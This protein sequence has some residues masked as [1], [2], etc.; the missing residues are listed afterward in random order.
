M[1]LLLDADGVVL[2]KHRYFSER[3][4]EERGVAIAEITPFFKNEFVRCQ[5]GQADLKEVLVPYLPKWKWDGTAD[6]FLDYWFTHDTE[7]DGAVLT[8]VARLRTAGTKCYLAS[9]QEKYRAAY[10]TK[11]IDGRLD[12][13]FYTSDLKMLKSD[14]TFFSEV[15]QRLGVDPHDVVYFDNSEPYIRAAASAGIDARLYSSID[16]ICT[17]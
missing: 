11:L 15:L 1:V 13:F 9:G 10:V 16:Q 17:L 6:E 5:A 4:A 12:G 7:L 8:E 2:K 3:Y 14:P